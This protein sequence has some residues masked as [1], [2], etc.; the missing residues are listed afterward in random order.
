MKRIRRK[1]KYQTYASYVRYLRSSTIKKVRGTIHSLCLSGENMYQ[2]EDK[3]SSEDRI[4]NALYYLRHEGSKS[5]EK[6]QRFKKT[7]KNEVRF[8]K[9]EFPT[10][11]VLE[12][13]FFLPTELD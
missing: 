5:P 6:I 9:E 8:L 3:L 4:E 2:E 10:S 7:L 1:R 11:Y 12:D 13:G